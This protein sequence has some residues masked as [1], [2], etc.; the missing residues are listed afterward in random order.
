MPHK[1]ILAVLSTRIKDRKFLRLVARLLKAGIQ[2]PGGVVYDELGSPQ[3]SIVSPAIANAFLDT[4]LDQWVAT[5]VKRHCRGYCEIIRYA[6]DS[7]AVFELEEDA[8]RFMRA[9]PLRLGKYGLRLNQT[10]THLLAFGKRRAWREFK[11]GQR[12][13]T[14]DFPGFTHYWVLSRRGL[15]R[16]KR[17]TAKRRLRRALVAINHWL[18]TE[19]NARPLPDLWQGLARKRRGHFNYFGVTDNSRA[20]YRFERAV[21]RI[22]FR[23]LNHRSQRRSFTWERFCRY[24]RGHPLPRPGHITSLNPV[25]GTAG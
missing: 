14:C 22:A 24:M 21:H 23:C 1:E 13:L 9:L 20:L 10:K 5:V 25:W 7:L 16:L 19:R 15:V 17:K 6:D 11:S 12:M 3:G 8:R 2:T 18:G 4:V